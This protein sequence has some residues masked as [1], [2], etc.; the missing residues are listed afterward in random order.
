MRRRILS[1]NVS[2]EKIFLFFSLLGKS[3]PHLVLLSGH[4]RWLFWLL[5]V[6]FGFSILQIPATIVQLMDGVHGSF[7]DWYSF[8]RM[9]V[10]LFEVGLAVWMIQIYQHHGVWA[11]GKKNLL[12]HRLPP[13][14]LE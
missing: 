10:A 14:F 7:P 8:G 3:I 11:M 12:S 5:L 9:G 13:N 1:E 2:D 4:W 6:A